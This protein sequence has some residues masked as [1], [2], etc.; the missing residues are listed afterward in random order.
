M[1]KVGNT[2]AGTELDVYL[3][4]TS[5][6][7]VSLLKFPGI[8]KLLKKYNTPLPSSAPVERL[9]S[10]GGQILV[11]KRNQMTD[12]HFERQLLLRANE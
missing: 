11:P 9:F 2:D 3:N 8:L 10:L 6:E 4:D 5:R 1:W 7:I 12:V